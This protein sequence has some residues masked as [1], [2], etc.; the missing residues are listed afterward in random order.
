GLE[1]II[2]P[3]VQ[4]AVVTHVGPISRIKQSYDF[5]LKRWLPMSD[6]RE[7]H[8]WHYQQYDARFKGIQDPESQTDLVFPVTLRKEQLELLP[9]A[10][11]SLNFDGGQIDVLWDHHADAIAWY[12]TRFKWKSDPTYDWRQ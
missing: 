6:Y 8:P 12:T 7:A 2:L 3:E 1:V 11:P 10:V 5:F 4:A 9:A